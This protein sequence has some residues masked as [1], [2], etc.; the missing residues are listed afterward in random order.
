MAQIMQV[1]TKGIKVST[2]K[3]MDSFTE[4]IRKIRNKI[5]ITIAKKL[6]SLTQLFVPSYTSTLKRSGRIEKG[7]YGEGVVI[8]YDAT[9][10][11]QEQAQE[12][13]FGK[14]YFRNKDLNGDESYAGIVDENTKFVSNAIDVFNRGEPIK[15]QAFGGTVDINVELEIPKR[16]MITKEDIKTFKRKAKSNYTIK[17]NE[18]YLKSLKSSTA[19]ARQK[20]YVGKLKRRYKKIYGVDYK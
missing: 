12:Q 9:V 14:V 7:E 4:D 10:E 15:M 13:K 5:P 20:K 3:L 16:G 1:D 2:K 8:V 18:E 19:K 6:D 17:S 11:E